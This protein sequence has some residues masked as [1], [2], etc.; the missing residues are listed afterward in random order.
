MGSTSVAA[1]RAIAARGIPNTAHDS[2]LSAMVHALTVKACAVIRDFDENG[3]GIV[4][5]AQCDRPCGVL[6]RGEARF[7]AFDPVIDG[8]PNHVRKRVFDQLDDRGVDFDV[9][10]LDQQPNILACC[11]GHI[12]HG[13]LM[14]VEGHAGRH[15]SHAGHLLLQIE[16]D[17]RYPRGTPGLARVPSRSPAPLR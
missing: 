11:L 5:R 13:P 14:L 15:H 10:T 2:S 12:A 9:R 16:K 1:P 8:V 4:R 3:A 6:A 7:R 17:G